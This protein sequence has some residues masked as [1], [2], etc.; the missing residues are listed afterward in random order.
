MSTSTEKIQEMVDKAYAY[1][2]VTEIE[3][4]TI[5]KGLNEEIVRII[6][7]KKEEPSWLL[8]WRLKAYRHWLTMDEPRWQNVHYP[9]I[10]YQAIRYY[11]APKIKVKPTSLDEIDPELRRTYEKLGISLQEQERLFG[12][13]GRRG[14]RQR[15]RRDHLQGEASRARNHLQQFL[16][17]GEGAPGAHPEVPRLGRPLHR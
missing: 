2:F 7:E 12:S 13:R 15:L 1:G 6:S 9:P 16:G 8:D 3:S 14:L 11:S 17:S 10:D 4:D 5:P